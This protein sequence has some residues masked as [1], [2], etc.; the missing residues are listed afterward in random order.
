MRIY[1]NDKSFRNNRITI[2]FKKRNDLVEE[3]RG[4]DETLKIE[5]EHERKIT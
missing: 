2:A 4:S 1:T 5:K 3:I